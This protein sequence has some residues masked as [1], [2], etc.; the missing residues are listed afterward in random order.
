MLSVEDAQAQVLARA[1]PLETELLDV[2]SALGRVLAEP[3]VSRRTIPPWPNSSMDGYAVRAAD[4][5]T[6]PAVLR[7]TARIAAGMVPD[8]P[9]G[10]G[11]AARI[12]TGA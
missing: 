12:F 1:R 3:V 8:R 7:V 9:I 4:T 6:A 10:P 11:E 5:E 2:P